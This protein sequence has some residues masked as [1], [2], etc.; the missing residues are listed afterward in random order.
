MFSA[1]S[2]QL[3][4]DQKALQ[5]IVLKFGDMNTHWKV[6]M[7]ILQKCCWCEMVMDILMFCRKSLWVM[8]TQ[9]I[10]QNLL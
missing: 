5:Q 8:K 10:L 1:Y 7:F 2:V 4:K 3:V 6:A 9:E